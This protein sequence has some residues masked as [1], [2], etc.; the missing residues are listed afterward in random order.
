MD[1]QLQPG[2]ICGGCDGFRAPEV[3]CGGARHRFICDSLKDAIGR[4]WPAQ[5]EKYAENTDMLV[6]AHAVKKAADNAAQN[7]E[8]LQNKEATNP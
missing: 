7:I 5:A 4:L 2:C 6:L 8:Y 3:W 1:N